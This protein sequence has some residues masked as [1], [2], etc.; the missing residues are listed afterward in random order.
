MNKPVLIILSDIFG[1]TNEEWMKEYEVRLQQ[2]FQVEVFDSRKLAGIQSTELSHVHNAFLN[3]GME[4]AVRAIE[5]FNLY[6]SAILGFSIGGTIAWK[7]ALTNQVASLYLVSATRL[8]NEIETPSSDVSL[9]FGEDEANG[10]KEDWFNK[11]KLSPKISRGA[12]HECYKEK[13]TIE[14]VCNDLL[15]CTSRREEISLNKLNN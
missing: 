2:S 10:P 7:Y 8:R 15:N 5:S 14:L 13:S 3:G 11:M 9:Y 4:Q 6:P 1:E 12:G